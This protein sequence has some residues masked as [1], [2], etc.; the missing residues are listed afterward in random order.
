MQQ[1]SGT[2]T[3]ALLHSFWQ[4]LLIFAA[5]RLVLLFIREQNSRLRYAAVTG[6][7]LVF[8][9]ASLGTL[10]FQIT[11][12]PDA[13]N[14]FSAE[15]YTFS[16]TTTDAADA[17]SFWNKIKSAISANSELLAVIWVFGASVFLVRA[18]GGL[19]YLRG[20]IQTGRIAEAIQ[21]TLDALRINLGIRRMVTVLES[22]AVTVPLVTGMLKPVIILPLGMAT[23]LSTAQIESILIHELIHIKRYDY[24]LNLV[25]AILESVFFFNPF[26]WILSDMMRRERE[27]CCDDAVIAAGIDSRTYAITL[28]SLE[29]ARH[30]RSGL[31]LSFAGKKYALLYRIKRLMEKSA[32]NYSARE[33]LVPVI[34]LVVGFA[35]ASWFTITPAT[36]NAI[37]SKVSLSEKSSVPG[38]TIPRPGKK[39]KRQLREN[40]QDPDADR[41]EEDQDETGRFDEEA[42]LGHFHFPDVHIPEMPDIDVPEFDFDHPGFPPPMMD[43]AFQ[44]RWKDFADQF[45]A[46]FSAR[47]G[48]FFEANEKELE[49]MME[50]LREKNSAIFEDGFEDQFQ[51]LALQEKALA[52]QEEVMEKHGKELE[53]FSEK[54]EQ[55]E[56]GNREHF[57]KLEAEMQEMQKQMEEFQEAL[58]AELVADGYLKEGEHARQIHWDDEGVLRVNGKEISESHRKKYED[59]RRKYLREKRE[60]K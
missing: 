9:I 47:F 3:F 10:T 25:Q 5:L 40:P 54:M 36:R 60:I 29:E 38:D 51:V 26:V 46:E 31:A 21:P 55:W 49:Q 1:L 7:L 44:A 27:H 23:G 42:D 48:E 15:L 14:L 12:Q 39:E 52:M 41:V 19:L 17:T 32:R 43:E 20:I 30:S 58:T 33:K 28:A 2:L 34:L 22:A 16:V 50:E 11:A 18:F 6:A 57:R 13:T 56:A 35:C 4:G 24:L 53:K 37:V 59:I 45:N 8:A